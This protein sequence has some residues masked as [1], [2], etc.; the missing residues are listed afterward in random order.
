M[1][2]NSILLVEYLEYARKRYLNALVTTISISKLLN[3]GHTISLPPLLRQSDLCRQLRHL[4]KIL[5]ILE[6]A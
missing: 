5:R 6:E 4:D 2:N 1:T 3:A